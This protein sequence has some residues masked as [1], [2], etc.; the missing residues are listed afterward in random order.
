MSPT[1]RQLVID[2]LAKWLDFENGNVMLGID[3]A[4]RRELGAFV[5]RHDGRVAADVGMND[6]LVMS[7]A[8]WAYV[9]E[10]NAPSATNSVTSEQFE[11]EQSFSVS[12]IWDEAAHIWA[13]QD[14]LDRK[15][16]RQARRVA[17]WR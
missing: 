16:S 5:V 7:T 2:T 3:R 13:I 10:E 17:T 8:I 1:R 14:K 12:H 9:V 15:W 6:D 11:S 4:L